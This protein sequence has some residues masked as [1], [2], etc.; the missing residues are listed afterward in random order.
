MIA[1]AITGPFSHSVGDI[2][3]LEAGSP[4]EIVKA[5]FCGAFGAVYVLD[6][7]DP[8]R[9]GTTAV[10]TPRA[11]LRLTDTGR[12]AFRREALLWADM[13]SHPNVL[14]VLAIP[15][16]NH[17]PYVR[18]IH[19]H[20]FHEDP[21]LERLLSDGRLA[22]SPAVAILSQM[23][24]G[25][26]FLEQ[27]WVGF[28]HGDLKP[29]NILISNELQV[30]IGDFGIA[31]SAVQ[32]SA[33][34]WVGDRRYQPPE[35][36]SGSRQPDIAADVFSFAATAFEMFWEPLFTLHDEVRLKIG[37]ADP[38][39]RA[40]LLQ[41][42]P[43]IPPALCDM[44][45]AGL[46]EDPA[47]RP[48]TFSEVAAAFWSVP[49]MK[50]IQLETSPRQPEWTEALSYHE[51]IDDYLVRVHGVTV[52]E[53]ANLLRGVARSAH[54][55]RLGA[56]MEARQ[57]ISD[58]LQRVPGFPISMAEAGHVFLAAGNVRGATMA[59]AGA[60][61][62]WG[63]TPHL[64][65]LDQMGYAG[66]CITLAQLYLTVDDHPEMW[67][68][69]SLLAD[70][71]H[72]LLPENEKAMLTKGFVAWRLGDQQ[73]VWEWVEKA[74]FKDPAN[75]RIRQ[76]YERLKKSV[77]TGVPVT[78]LFHSVNHVDLAPRAGELDDLAA[79]LIAKRSPY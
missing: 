39:T 52:E 45:M 25:L 78:H 42:R 11:D 79:Y 56:V 74:Y 31:R 70:E 57:V 53:A 72:S 12:A 76:N 8:H 24:E 71:G 63:R 61:I 19:I 67:R 43:D 21:S 77:E 9:P 38:G 18:T 4:P 15:E 23:L 28:S 69:A 62:A 51:A 16:Y 17:R 73:K 66:A 64:R 37:L 5:R 48:R 32:E 27:N 58:V 14:P 50:R 10:K 59:F 36:S 3:H 47:R 34:E 46:A 2:V 35:V 20:G 54:L 6:S 60:I 55:R 29:S 40:M 41:D 13:P 22:L 49:G 75:A 7:A 1:D 68:V 30:F 33:P 65:R 26:G 44:I